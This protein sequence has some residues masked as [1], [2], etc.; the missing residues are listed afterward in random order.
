MAAG[1]AGLKS[2]VGE[3]YKCAGHGLSVGVRLW[4]RFRVCEMPVVSHSAWQVG[5]TEQG[6]K[7]GT[8]K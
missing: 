2:R 7:Y 6:W 3:S 4:E 5:G 8:G 1:P